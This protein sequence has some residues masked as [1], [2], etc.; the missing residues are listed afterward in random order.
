[1]E[2][3][4][5]SDEKISLSLQMSK[6]ISLGLKKEIKKINP[7]AAL[8]KPK[9]KLNES[10]SST[11]EKKLTAI[12]QIMQEEEQKKKRLMNHTNA[13]VKKLRS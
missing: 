8:A 2:E 3:L 11:S 13:P 1:M 12:E 10:I 6:P 9:A 7:F 4:K 5:R